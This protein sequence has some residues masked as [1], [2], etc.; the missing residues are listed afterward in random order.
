MKKKTNTIESL[1][2][3]GKITT[4]DKIEPKFNMFVEMNKLQAEYPP[5]EAENYVF[6][7]AA[8][9]KQIKRLKIL[10]QI[11]DYCS[12]VGILPEDLIKCHKEAQGGL[13]KKKLGKVQGELQN[14]A[15]EA[16]IDK[17]DHSKWNE[18]YKKRKLFGE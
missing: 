16:V 7:H 18:N 13:K 8:I 14:A 11:E 6:N 17:K 3:E 15:N 4:A 12:T 2:E 5:K 9:E 10:E 1:K